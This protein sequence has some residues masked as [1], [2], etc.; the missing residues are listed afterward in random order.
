MGTPC[1][2][3]GTIEVDAGEGLDVVLAD[4][5]Y[6]L[7]IDAD[8]LTQINRH[9]V[10][11][12][13]VARDAINSSPSQG[14]TALTLDTNRR[15]FFDG[16]GWI[17]T[18]EPWQAYTPSSTNITVGSG[19][20]AGRYQRENG[21]CHFRA[22]F[23]LGGGSAMG[24]APTIGLPIATAGIPMNHLYVGITDTGTGFFTGVNLVVAAS[25]ASVEIRY[26][27]SAGTPVTGT[28]ITST[29]PMTWASTDIL[30]VGGTFEMSSPYL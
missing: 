27:N 3:V 28:G 24:T 22:S 23:T 19:A 16:T 7:S 9:G 20:L 11:A 25:G 29:A 17:I 2:P 5:I 13:V 4:G 21:R 14:D 18:G 26:A 6:S 8:T 30:T 10:Y 12:S 15:Y 1:A